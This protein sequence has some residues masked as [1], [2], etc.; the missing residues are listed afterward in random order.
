MKDDPFGWILL[1]AENKEKKRCSF[2]QEFRL[3]N[4]FL[5]MLKNGQTYLKNPQDF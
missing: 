1:A 4:P 2:S 5:T 3:F